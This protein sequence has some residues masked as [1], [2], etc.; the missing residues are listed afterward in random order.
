MISL[1]RNFNFVDI[2]N[3]CCIDLGSFWEVL[4]NSYVK[5]GLASGALLGPGR[6]WLVFCNLLVLSKFFDFNLPSSSA[7]A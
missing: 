1:F 2:L 5:A 3:L 4:H 6:G 7:L